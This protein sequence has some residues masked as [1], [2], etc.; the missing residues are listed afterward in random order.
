M[1]VAS[2]ETQTT[3]NEKSEKSGWARFCLRNGI[4]PNLVMLKITL[5]VMHGGR[6]MDDKVTLSVH[7]SLQTD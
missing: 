4:N 3:Y 6:R 1:K 7:M 2:N 5:F